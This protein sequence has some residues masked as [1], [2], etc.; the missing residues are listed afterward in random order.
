MKKATEIIR[1]ITAV[2]TGVGAGFALARNMLDF[3]RG[4]V[5][6]RREGVDKE[7]GDILRATGDT[8]RRE[9]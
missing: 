3:S 5:E 4:L 6:A 9:K 1:L 7:I 2:L 8:A